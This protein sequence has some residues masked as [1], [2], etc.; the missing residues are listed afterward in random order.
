MRSAVPAGRMRRWNAWHTAAGAT[1][2]VEKALAA[3]LALVACGVV[4]GTDRFG[5]FKRRQ[6]PEIAL[7]WVLPAP[8]RLRH[9]LAPALFA[10]MQCL[11]PWAVHAEGL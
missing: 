3:L 7:S 8:R 11:S 5:R 2:A 9:S 10:G 4:D 1:G 6:G